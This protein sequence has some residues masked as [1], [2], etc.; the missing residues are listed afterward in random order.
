MLGM[1]KSHFSIDK[2]ISLKSLPKGG[3]IHVIG[4]AGVAMAQLAVEL[5]KQGFLV[6]GSDK[7]FYEPM[8]SLL[9]N[10]AVTLFQ[11]YNAT[12]IPDS[13][14]LVVI[15]NAISYG[16]PEVTVVEERDLP[17]TCFPR[18]CMKRSSRVSAPSLCPAHT[19]SQRQPR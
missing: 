6:S 8:G 11:G 3:R 4:V 2:T 14:D 15:G 10:S 16:N 5:T 17:Y 12:N 7:D 1:P 19:A 9:K 18:S 13:V